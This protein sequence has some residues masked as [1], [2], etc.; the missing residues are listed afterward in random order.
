MAGEVDRMLSCMRRVEM[1]D[2]LTKEIIRREICTAPE[3]QCVALRQ[4]AEVRM[5]SGNHRR[6]RMEHERYTA[7]PERASLPRHVIGDFRGE[8]A[9]DVRPVDASLLEQRATFEHSCHT[10]TATR[11]LPCIGREFGGAI[12]VGEC[13]T[14]LAL[15]LGEE[16][17]RT[18]EQVGHARMLPSGIRRA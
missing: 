5:R 8:L 11:P 1:L 13:A 3:P 16:L 7:R 6:A 9:I 15:E 17:R 10:S 4:T 12:G 14:Q 2:V 18:I